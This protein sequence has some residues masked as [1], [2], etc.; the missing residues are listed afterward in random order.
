MAS[1]G[2]EDLTGADPF[3]SADATP[4]PGVRLFARPLDQITDGPYDLI[5]FHHSLEHVPDQHITM[6]A[7]SRLLAPNG[8]CLI[9]IPTVTS[10]VWEKYGTGWVEFDAPRHF[11][12][13]SHDSL[14][15][16]ATMHNMHVRDITCDGDE[17][18]YWA[19]ELYR[20][21]IPIKNLATGQQVDQTA[22]F[23]TEELGAFASIA[24][25]DNAALRGGRIVALLSSAHEAI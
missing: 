4:S 13:H 2:F 10:E 17:F 1:I 15:Q 9:R 22:H 20:R 5:M 11:F 21:D 8:T 7:V 6:A 3:L 18:G 23:Q 19:S 12:L 24:A 14:R 25:A 16:L